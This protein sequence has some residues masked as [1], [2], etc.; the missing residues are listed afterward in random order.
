M[1]EED[2]QGANACDNYIQGDLSLPLGGYF[3]QL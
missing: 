2:E 3:S 1:V